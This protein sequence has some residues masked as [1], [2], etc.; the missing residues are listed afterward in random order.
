VFESHQAEFIEINTNLKAIKHK[1]TA[2]ITAQRFQHYIL[3]YILDHVDAIKGDR[4]VA[5]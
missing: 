5:A 2:R 4:T 3:N 1:K